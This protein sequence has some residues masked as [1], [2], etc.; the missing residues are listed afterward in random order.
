MPC[1]SPVSVPFYRVE[2]GFRRFSV[3]DA[4]FVERVPVKS[5]HYINVPCGK[6]PA[7]L[8][9]LQMQWSFRI[10]QEVLQP[11]VVSALFVTLT[12]SPAFLPSDLS[13]HK[14]DVQKYIKRLRI[15]LERNFDKD[16]RLSFYACGEYGDVY[17]RPH[18]HLILAFS[19]SVPFKIIQSSW[20]RGIVDISPF[21][22]A[23]AGYVAKYSQKQFGLSYGGL[24]P[25][26]RLCSKGLGKSFL[27][28]KDA[29][30][31]GYS[32][33]FR[34]LSG[35]SVVLHRYYIDKLYRNY[36]YR[37]KV[38]DTPFGELRLSTRYKVCNRSRGLY[39]WNAEKRYNEYVATSSF[40]HP[41]GYLGFIQQSSIGVYNTL[42]YQSFRLTEKQFLR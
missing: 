22:L 38:V 3:G 39:L 28:G 24:L 17:N 13:V 21:T 2:P 31:L 25:P 19:R 26:F 34:N 35:R 15:N 33:R 5:K 32:N 1:L 42:L 10:E 7:C 41:N 16:L 14:E 11:W 18:Y 4:N 27:V 36:E 8:A 6:C 20:S 40:S 23:R 9:R 30:S 37:Y 12:Y 29:R